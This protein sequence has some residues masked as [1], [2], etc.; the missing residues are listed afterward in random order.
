[1]TGPGRHY[2]KAKDQ[3]SGQ[4]VGYVG[5]LGPDIEPPPHSAVPRPTFMNL[6][7][8]NELDEKLKSTRDKYLTGRKDVWCK[9]TSGVQLMGDRGC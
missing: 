2:F 1:M 7:L 3:E 4:V 5:L 8:D 9:Y 6:E